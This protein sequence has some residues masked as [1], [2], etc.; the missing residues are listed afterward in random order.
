MSIFK[1]DKVVDQIENLE[2]V[3]MIDMMIHQKRRWEFRNSLFVKVYS[4]HYV[5]QKWLVA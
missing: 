4:Q 3:G 5:W 2:N 1:R